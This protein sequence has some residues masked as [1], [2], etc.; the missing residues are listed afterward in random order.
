VRLILNVM[1]FGARPGP[2]AGVEPWTARFIGVRQGRKNK[3]LMGPRPGCVNGGLLGSAI[4][5]WRA[6]PGIIRG[7]GQ[8]DEYHLA[9]CSFVALDHP[10]VG[11]YLAFVVYFPSMGAGRSEEE[12]SAPDCGELADGRGCSIAR[13]GP[14][15]A[16]DAA[17]GVAYHPSPPDRAVCFQRTPLAGF[18]TRQM[19]LKLPGRSGGNWASDWAGWP[20]GA[21]GASLAREPYS[22]DLGVGFFAG[23]LFLS[24]ASASRQ[25]LSASAYRKIIRRRH[26]FLAGGD[27]IAASVGR[28]AVRDPSTVAMT[29]A[30]ELHAVHAVIAAPPYLEARSTI[31]APFARGG[32]TSKRGSVL[33]VAFDPALDR[34]R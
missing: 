32:K 16:L 8:F 13:G 6:P 29:L 11:A 27:G 2:W 26:P 7:D 20:F 31:A 30:G 10:G 33:W 22:R 5:G 19:P 25:C 18:K 34:R 17:C 23:H 14:A 12:L 9:H 21:G 15:V 28:D 24:D 1:A 4:L 3:P